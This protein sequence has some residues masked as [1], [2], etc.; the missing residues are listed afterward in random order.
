MISFLHYLTADFF[1]LQYQAAFSDGVSIVMHDCKAY[2]TAKVRDDH[3]LVETGNKKLNFATLLVCIYPL[4]STI[5][6]PD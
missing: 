4:V 5:L 3:C 1:L 2:C 6:V